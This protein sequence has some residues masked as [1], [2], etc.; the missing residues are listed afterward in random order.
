MTFCSLLPANANAKSQGS[1]EFGQPHAFAFIGEISVVSGF[2][3]LFSKLRLAVSEGEVVVLFI[4]RGM[5]FG[6]HFDFLYSDAAVGP[7]NQIGIGFN[8]AWPLADDGGAVCN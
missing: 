4:L 6:T 3:F 2:V 8:T 7:H 1:F 5:F